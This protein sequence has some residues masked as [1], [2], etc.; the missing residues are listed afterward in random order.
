MKL[1]D[2]AEINPSIKLKQHEKYPFVEMANLVPESRYVD[3]SQLREYKGSCSK[4]ENGDIL[5]ARI[6]P[7]LQNGKIS[8]YRSSNPK[9]SFGSTEF[10]VLRAKTNVSDSSFLYYLASSALITE[11]AIKS[12]SGASGRQRVD[13]DAF[14]NIELELPSLTDQ[15]KIGYFLTAYDDLIRNNTHR[16]KSLEETCQ[17][18]YEE[19][20]LNYKILGF[21]S[22]KLIYTE[23]GR[24]P[25]DWKIVK[26]G[27]VLK[28]S[29]G[30]N[31]TKKTVIDGGVPVIAGGLQPAYYHNAANTCAPVITISASGANAGYT[32]LYNNKVWA[33]DCSYIDINTTPYVYY[34]YLLLKNRHR[35]IKLMQRGAAQP[36]VYPKD[37]MDLKIHDVPQEIIKDFIKHIEP[38]FKL[39][40]NLQK[41]NEVLSTTRD[42]LIP[43]LI[44]GELSV[45]NLEVR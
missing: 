6:T 8:Q 2:F 26:L 4:F 27:N 34:Y 23:L 44:S 14:K 22:E 16:I 35:D 25:E 31:I 21:E 9:T 15:K 28:I 36:H 3:Y 5:F 24:S 10:I 30:K 29:K 42:L 19:W 12:M 18:F 13:N 11:P 7:C 43:R 39:I 1:K 20:F 17:R 45:N 40:A 38:F 41:Q 37:L 32:H 33:S